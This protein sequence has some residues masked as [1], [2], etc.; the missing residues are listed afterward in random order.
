VAPAAS[1]STE[2]PQASRWGEAFG[3]GIRTFVDSLSAETP[4]HGFKIAMSNFQTH[5]QRKE[6]DEEKR[7]RDMMRASQKGA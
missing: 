2:A 4:S 5:L 6:A 7:H 1:S 3:F